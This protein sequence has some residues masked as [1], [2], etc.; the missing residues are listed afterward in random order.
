MVG[1]ALRTLRHRAGGFV[2]SFAATLLGA[3]ILMTFA[4]MLDTAGGPNVDPLTE[5]QL[6][7][8]AGVAGG[9]CLLIVAFAVTSTLTLSVRQRDKEI[10]LL[11]SV[12]ATPGQVGRM[13]VVEAAAVSLLAA[14]LA[15]PLGLAFGRVMF[16]LSSDAGII[17]PGVS[18]RFGVFAIGIG[19]GVTVLGAVIAALVTSRRVSRMAAR[20]ALAAEERP[21]LSRKRVALAWLLIAGSVNLGVLTIVLFSGKGVDAMQTAGSASILASAGFALL[22]PVLVRGVTA[23][24]AGPLRGIAGASGYL[25]V[26]NLRRR[27]QQMAGALMPIILFT[28]ISTGTLYMQTIENRAPSVGGTLT[29]DV[30]RTVET[31]NLVVVGMLSLFAAIM[32]VNTLIAATTYRRQEFGQQRLAGATP[33]QVRRMVLVES[34]V[35]TITGLLF[36]SLASLATIVPYSI[37]R[38]DSILPDAPVFIWPAIALVAALL[39]LA[40]SLGTTRRALRT[41]ATQAVALT[42]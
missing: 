29:A 24:L 20:E 7:T 8:M 21:R 10:A 9:W 1:I 28:G 30:E 40:A 34:A 37:A 35:L 19:I 42:G 22:A 4:S 41:P 38:T 3:T 33:R 5:E 32:V 12:G 18:Y 39:T 26:H 27:S 11:K 16:D 36:G 13:I 31:L 25:S 23:V 2:A 6:V 15:I 14:V 17:A